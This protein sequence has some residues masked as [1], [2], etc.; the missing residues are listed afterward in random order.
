MLYKIARALQLLGLVIAPIG[1][2][3]NVAERLSL[4][5]SLLVAGAGVL[6]FFVGWLLQESTR[7]Q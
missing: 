2:M 5:D 4:R 3:G 1:V 6:V 7:P